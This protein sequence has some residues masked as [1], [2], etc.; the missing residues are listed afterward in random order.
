MKKLLFLI[1][2]VGFLMNCGGGG[3]RYL[4]PN[5]AGGSGTWGPYEIKRVTKKMVISLYNNLRSANKPALLKVMRIKNRTSEH[6]DTKLLSEQ[7]ATN[8]IQKR[9]QFID[10]SLD[11]SAIK[12]MKDGMTGMIDPNY[13][14]PI[15][16]LRSPNMYLYGEVTDNVRST[17]GR[18]IQYLVVTLKLREVATRMILWQDRKEFLKSTNTSRIS[19]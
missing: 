12:E 17:G 15:G 14:V 2:I 10:D 9:I 18:K 4:D 16:K 19:F 6:I 5:R 11:S 13:S 7:I 3:T 1:T 8:L